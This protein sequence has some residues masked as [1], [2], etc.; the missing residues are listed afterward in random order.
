GMDVYFTTL[1][2]GSRRW[3]GK[4]ER[5][6][7][8]PRIDN[9]VVLYTGLFNVD[10][11]DGALLMGM[12]T[13][14]F[15]VTSAAHDVLTVPV[16]ALTYLDDGPAGMSG[17]GR[18]SAAGRPNGASR[19]NPADRDAFAQRVAERMRSGAPPAGAF[20]EGPPGVSPG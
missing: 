20:P 18:P 9:N 7:P 17:I 10:N 16:G 4:L 8:T 6:L 2:G 13:Q 12:T 5:F 14:V 19:T 15:F 1:G 11:S 3:Y